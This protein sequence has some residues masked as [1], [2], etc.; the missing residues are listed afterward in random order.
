MGWQDRAY[1]RDDPNGIPPVQF[2]L[3]KISPLVMTL[4][5]VNFG[6]FLLKFS[7]QI[8][9]LEVKWASL[10]LASPARWWQLWRLITYQ[11]IHGGVGHVFF[12][13]LGVY[14]F[15]PT[16]ERRWGWEKT[17]AFYTLG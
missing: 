1:N 8:E 3:P 9:L 7:P 12:N 10:S 13:M 15:V 17:F 2:T 14:F 11:Y 5:C 4:L 6:L 16:L